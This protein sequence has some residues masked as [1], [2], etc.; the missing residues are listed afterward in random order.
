MVLNRCGAIG[1][2]RMRDTNSHRKVG[3]Q[4]NGPKAGSRHGYKFGMGHQDVWSG[5]GRRVASDTT[6]RDLSSYESHRLVALRTV[7]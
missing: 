6:R 3:E 4:P 2:T 1:T 5:R 7:A